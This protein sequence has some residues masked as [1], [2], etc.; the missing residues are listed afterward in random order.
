MEFTVEELRN[1]VYDFLDENR[2]ILEERVEYG[3]PSASVGKLIESFI[4]AAAKAAIKSAP[5][6]EIDETVR[7]VPPGSPDRRAAHMAVLELP[8]DFFR[9]VYFRMDD[10][11]EGVTAALEY[12]S[13]ACQ[14]RRRLGPY[15]YRMACPAVS[16]R[17]R[18][19]RYLLM[20]YGTGPESKAAD[21]EYVAEPKL[22]EGK[23]EFPA[24]LK[25]DV[26]ERVAEKVRRV[27]GIEG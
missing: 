12:G 17:R 9:L 5:L 7:V 16:L 13:S 14:L 6:S 26:C 25:E 27:M 19:E 23:I 24:G 15:G 18:G 8:A 10:W 2:E 3:D 22:R 4:P 11:E 1:R 21:L 20:I